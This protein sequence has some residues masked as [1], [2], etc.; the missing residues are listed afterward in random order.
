MAGETREEK[1][2]T[3]L[4]WLLVA[5][6]GVAIVAW[7]FL[8]YFTVGDKGP[9]SWDYGIVEDVPGEAPYSLYDSQLYRGLGVGAAPVGKVEAQHVSGPPEESPAT[10]PK[11]SR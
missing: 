2:E 5:G 7:G 8:I 4:S 11:G 9:P 1:R 3:V 6:F 10:S